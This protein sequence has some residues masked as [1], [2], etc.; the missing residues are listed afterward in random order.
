MILP[1]ILKDISSKLESVGAKTVVVGGAVRDYFL[2]LPIKDYD[3]EV[4]GLKK[5]DELEKIL[6][7][8]GN[9]SLVGKSFGVLKLSVDR[10]EYDFS[11]PRKE[12]QTGLG[13]RA[14]EVTC[15]GSLSFEEASRRRDFTINAIGYDIALDIFLDPF[16]GQKD[17]Q[18]SVLRHIDDETFIED[19]LRVYRAV[20]FAAR[21]ECKLAPQ[22]FTLCQ[23]MIEEGMLETLPKERLYKEWEKLLLKSSRPSE[24]FELMRRL[25]ILRYFPELESLIGT[26][27]SPKWHPEGDVW[28]HT[29]MSLD[30]MAKQ[31]RQKSLDEKQ[32][33][34]YM[35]AILCHD[36]GKPATTEIKENKI[37]SIG[38]ETV[39]IELTQRFMYRLTN[40]HDFIDS[41]LPLVEHHLKPSQFYKHK[42]KDKAI[43]RLATKVNIEELV[44]V[45]KADFFG[46][47]T[48]EAQKGVYEAGDWLLERARA[49]KVEKRPLENLLKGRDLITLGLKPSEE[50]G[51]ILSDVYEHQ[52]DGTLEDRE[53]ALTYVRYNYVSKV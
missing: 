49:L 29:M 26:L 39:G 40:E 20:Q 53:A 9:V 50:F 30:A 33:L 11:F 51:M 18:E 36:L 43:R 41:I 13:H 6:S 45:A 48:L 23:K 47:T 15:D 46:R 8:F 16:E 38:H 10:D 27:Q 31:L 7:E 37:R 14:F 2:D 12:K 24:G 21:F 34:K 19:P 52:L 4:Y 32:Y 22:T 17:M 28:V 25:G 44:E 3:I 5:M 1:A 42:A 35:Y